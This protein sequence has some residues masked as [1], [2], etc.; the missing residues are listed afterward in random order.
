MENFDLYQLAED[1]GVAVKALVVD[2]GS[3][4]TMALDGRCYIAIDHDVFESSDIERMHLAHELGHCM[5][6]SFFNPHSKLDI[7]GKHERRAN[8]WAYKQVVPLEG[9][10]KCFKQ[11]LAEAWQME[12][13]FDVPAWFIRQA[14]EYYQQTTA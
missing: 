5:T 6:G 14:M 7:R 13:V 2:S 1:E 9:I 8:A 12:D 11:G 3:A 4:S 10:R